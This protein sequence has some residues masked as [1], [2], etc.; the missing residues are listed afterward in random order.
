[1]VGMRTVRLPG[2]VGVAIVI[3]MTLSVR[4]AD[5]C[6]GA[7]PLAMGGAFI[8]VADDAN[9]TYWN[10][11]ALALMN[12]RQVTAVYIEGDQLNYKI[13]GSYSQSITDQF[14]LGL[15]L[16][17]WN[18]MPI[19]VINGHLVEMDYY[20]PWVSLGMRVPSITVGELAV[21][22]NI[23]FGQGEL[24]WR[25]QKETLDIDPGLDL[26]VIYRL[27]E[28]WSFGLLIQDINE[29]EVKVDGYG[30]TK[31]KRNIRPGIAYRHNEKLTLSCDIYDATEE[32]W[33]MVGVEY[34]MTPRIGVRGGVYAIGGS[35]WPT[36]GG[37]YHV[38]PQFSIEAGVMDFEHGIVSA[39]LTF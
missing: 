18:T 15:S 1:M 37:T 7:R 33:V 30:F 14:A 28:H 22:A 6:V 4:H 20:R 21:G 27:N 17:T 38:T 8:A 29:P 10:P 11:A 39:G 34:W 13:F 9:S 19:A 12:S 31:W 32:N 24:K 36:L 3:G 23:D 26:S 5:A 25:G 16:Y 35:E 2:C